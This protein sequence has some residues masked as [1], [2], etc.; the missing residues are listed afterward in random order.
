MVVAVPDQR[1]VSLPSF[2][3]SSACFFHFLHGRCGKSTFQQ[4]PCTASFHVAPSIWQVLL[5]D[6]QRTRK[7]IYDSGEFDGE[8]E[9]NKRSCFVK[10]ST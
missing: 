2:R 5:A 9:L 8:F 10:S 3:S 4:H 1:A 7:S 6:L